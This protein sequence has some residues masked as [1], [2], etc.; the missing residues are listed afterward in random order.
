M[1]FLAYAWHFACK[2]SVF[3]KFAP[4]IQIYTNIDMKHLQK[5]LPLLFA[6]FLFAACEEDDYIEYNLIGTWRVVEVSGNFY[7]CPYRS[8]DYM[9]FAADGAFYADLCSTQEYGGYWVRNGHIYIDF[10]AYGDEELR[11]YVRRYERDYLVLDVDDYS[12]QTRYTL[13]LVREY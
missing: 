10:D 1:C 4:K 5:I 13:R 3:C 9:E 6:L 11:A 12:F 2:S 7:N 8:G